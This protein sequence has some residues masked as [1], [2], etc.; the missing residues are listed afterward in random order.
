MYAPARIKKREDQ[1]KLKKPRFCT[2]V[3]KCVEVNGVIFK[4]VM[5]TVT[6]TSFNIR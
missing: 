4:H 3:A 2:R 5:G 6:N 1:L